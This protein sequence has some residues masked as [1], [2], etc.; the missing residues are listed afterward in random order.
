M[1]EQAQLAAKIN[2][3]RDE[4]IKSGVSIPFA[5]KRRDPAEPGRTEKEALEDKIFALFMKQF[6]KQKKF[7]KELLTE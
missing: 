6:R 1:T 7:I 4:L 2:D 3:L 5:L